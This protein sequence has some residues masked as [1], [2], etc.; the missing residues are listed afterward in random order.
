MQNL[1]QALS[2]NLTWFGCFPQHR[3]GGSSKSLIQSVPFDNLKSHTHTCLHKCNYVFWH[4]LQS[5]PN[6]HFLTGLLAQMAA[7]VEG[8]GSPGGGPG[9]AGSIFFKVGLTLFLIHVATL[10]LWVLTP[11]AAILTVSIRSP[12]ENRNRPRDMA[13]SIVMLI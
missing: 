7:D 4:Y 11:S 5:G 2:G 6:N 3:R 1:I 12:W 10:E 8:W 13:V 9:D